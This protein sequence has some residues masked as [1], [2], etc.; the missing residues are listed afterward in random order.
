MKKILA[1][2]ALVLG[3]FFSAGS[4]AAQPAAD[5][6]PVNDNA[7]ERTDPMWA[8]APGPARPGLPHDQGHVHH[9]TGEDLDCHHAIGT[10]DPNPNP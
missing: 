2:M 10:E 9:E 8:D 1:I 5:A 4:A 6:R 7:C 3:A